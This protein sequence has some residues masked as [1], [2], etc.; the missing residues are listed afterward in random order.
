M[1]LFNKSTNTLI[2]ICA[3][4]CLLIS[5]C[6]S[7]DKSP[8]R[9]AVSNQQKPQDMQVSQTEINGNVIKGA[10][11]NADVYFYSLS[12]SGVAKTPFANTKTDD[13]GSFS[14]TIPSKTLSD[15]IY[16]EVQAAA[17]GSSKMVCDVD[18]C[19][20]VGSARG[21][22]TNGNGQFDFGETIELTDDFYLSGAITNF[23][24]SESLQVS[25]TPIS[26]LAVQR[27]KRKGK[28]DANSINIEMS[29]LAALF[30]LPATLSQLTALDI[31]RLPD[32]DPALDSIRYSLYSAAIAGYAN[33]HQLSLTAALKKIEAELFDADGAV[34]RELLV[35]LLHLAREGAEQLAK[36][37]ESLQH[38]IAQIMLV[39]NRYECHTNPQSC[40]PVEPPKPP[41]PPH[42]ELAKVK[43]LV[44]DFRSWVRDLTQQSNPALANFKART[45]MV[46][47]IWEDDIKVLGS[48][49][50]DVLP[51]VAQAVSPTY[52]FCY[53][54]EE[55]G[56]AFAAASTTKELTLGN[57]RYQ[58]FSDGTL[59]IEGSIRDVDVDIQL[60]FPPAEEFAEQH[61]IAIEAGRLTRGNMELVISKGSLISAEFPDGLRFDDAISAIR[62]DLV[63]AA[64]RLTAAVNFSIE[65][66]YGIA[67]GG[68]IDF[69]SAVPVDWLD[70]GDWSV[71]DEKSRSGTSSLRSPQIGDNTSTRSSATINTWGGYLS[72]NY[73][74]ESEAG[75]DFFN[76]YVDGQKVLSASGFQPGFKNAQIFLT[77]GE[78]TVVW[79]Y[80]K[81]GSVGHN[82]D[83]VWLDDIQYPTLAG[84]ATQELVSHNILSGTM[85]VS[86]HKLDEPWYFA[87][88]GYLPGEI[89]VKA[90]FSN[91]FLVVDNIE[92]DE[93]T[94]NFAAT[95]AN[96]A[97]FAPSQP[98]DEGTLGLLGNYTVSDD[99]FTFNLQDW[100]IRITPEGN[101]TYRYEMFRPG[102]DTPFQSYLATSNKTSMKDVAGDL[103]D[104]SGIGLQIVV[105]QEGLYITTLLRSSPWGSY[106]ESRFDAAGGN[107]YGYLV[108]PY[109]PTETEDQFLRIAVAFE[110]QLRPYDLPEMILGSNFTRDT[111]NE[112]TFA[113]YL[114]VDGKRFNFSSS[115]WYNLMEFNNNESSI[116]AKAPTLTI[117]NH[118]G[119]ILEL[120]FPDVDNVG[121]GKQEP[122]L[123]GN[124]RYNNV[125][126]GTVK[127]VKGIPTIEYIDGTGESID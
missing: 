39:I 97:E 72:F 1:K 35:E 19:G 17:D 33:R 90:V 92:E 98:Y 44:G 43:E 124:L 101:Q 15:A 86:A 9:N 21:E 120:T 80:A 82:K 122:T 52:Q 2:A 7:S 45:E 55:D 57:L 53:Y 71:T 75:Y 121:S 118:N 110:L 64:T 70:T 62:N 93:I 47:R 103:I 12:E 79:E 11:K 65:A 102:E 13:N 24:N 84:D 27:A 99:L 125:V 48:A 18:V 114:I 20:L 6:S 28:L 26:H 41:Q 56:I 73:A 83:A 60:R 78:H 34:N 117:E 100:S 30:N 49:L 105:P 23:K 32:G 109:Q 58:L 38:L 112:G 89:L 3:S 5:G 50:N 88:Q 104:N 115:Y 63:P 76:V 85:S 16:V 96:A 95:I 107:I 111:L 126:Y 106:D 123:Q 81:D 59:D 4:S 68:T 54:C 8:S 108:E 10:V 119:V 37:K 46:G 29:E 127:T 40:G 77:P 67:P 31:T 74:V 22:D 69:E 113:F 25:V 116:D 51:G 36:G 14:I 42:G 61:S 87:T 94:L 66:E 91:Q